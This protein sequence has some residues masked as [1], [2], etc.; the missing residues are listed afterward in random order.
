MSRAAATS[1]LRELDP[2]DPISW[3]FSGFS[4]N[5]ED[6]II[7][8][9]ASRLRNPNYYFVEI[10]AA[11]GLE[12]NTSWLAIARRY[13]GLMLE[14]DPDAAAVCQQMISG[15]GGLNI[16][17]ESVCARVTRENAPAIGRR[18]LFR[19]ADVY[20]IDIDGNDYHVTEALLN[21]GFRPKICVVEYNS[22]FGPARSMTVQY[23]SD[24][25]IDFD[26]TVGSLYYGASITGWRSLFVKN[27]YVFVTVEPSGTNA[28]FIDPAEFEPNF[29]KG[30]KGLAFQENLWQLMRLRVGWREQFELI[31]DRE[32]VEVARAGTP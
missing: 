5:G 9:L 23:R 30:L 24:H 22:A 4:Q 26:D 25:A 19:D 17:V 13:S 1:S 28:F 18:A 27:G 15:R 12:N 31:E 21:A 8:Y 10:G 2:T 7:D 20:S 11:D 32:F 29:V 16:R 6:G 14:A 3:S